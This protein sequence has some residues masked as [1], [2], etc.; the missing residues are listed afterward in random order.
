MKIHDKNAFFL[1]ELNKVLIII[2]ANTKANLK[3]QGRKYLAVVS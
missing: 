3:Q 2:S 1:I